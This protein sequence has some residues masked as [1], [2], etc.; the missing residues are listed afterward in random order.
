MD[1]HN[2]F[3]DFLDELDVSHTVGYSAADYRKMSFRS[4]FGLKKLLEKY[5]IDSEGVRIEDKSEYLN[6]PVPFLAQTPDGFVIVTETSP[7]RINYRS[8]GAYMECDSDDFLAAWTGVALIAYPGDGASEPDYVTHRIAERGGKVKRV[9]LP[10]CGAILLIGL[11]V[12]NGLW[13][14]P[15]LW[16]V[17]LF[18]IVGLYFSFLL[19]Q[20]SAG[21]SSRHADAVCGVLQK[22]GCDSILS[23][24][25]AKFYG[26]FGWSEVGLTYFGVSLG[27][28]LVF[29]HYV[30][31]LALCNLCC[32]PFSFWS[33][34][35]QKFRARHWCTLC[36][37]VQ[38][39][40]WA[41]FFCYLSGGWI[42]DILPFKV[43]LYLV[44]LTYL[45]VLLAINA[46][47]PLIEKNKQD[48]T[49]NI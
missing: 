3:S 36:V 35:Y 43:P 33:I 17:T 9:L 48:E 8:A 23:S 20:K 12:Y 27:I 18:S 40:L 7:Q 14:F 2:L 42:T 24:G 47:M 29:P 37:G 34:W 19:V 6:L 38:A 1:E 28:L 30:N 15:S 49:N 21:F 5:G 4:L 22:K 11:F 44:G 16:F 45:T 32:L 10:V 46:L 26:L 31:W 41:L 39:T 25:A 13:H